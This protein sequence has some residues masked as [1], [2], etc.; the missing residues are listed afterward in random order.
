MFAN[1][2]PAAADYVGMANVKVVAYRIVRHVGT[3][4][5]TAFFKFQ[6]DVPTAQVDIRVNLP[7][8]IVANGFGQN[9]VICNEPSGQIIGQCYVFEGYTY[10]NFRKA[11]G[12]NWVVTTQPATST[13]IEGQLTF[14]AQGEPYKE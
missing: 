3:T 8:G 12:V 7:N 14:E 6:F 5:V 9:P 11:P 13:F 2:I 1:Y 10:L 4:L